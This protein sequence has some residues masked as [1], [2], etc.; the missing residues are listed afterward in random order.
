MR[1][2]KWDWEQKEKKPTLVSATGN[3]KQIQV[4]YKIAE[5]QFA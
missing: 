1:G 5:L 2:R 3:N 4:L